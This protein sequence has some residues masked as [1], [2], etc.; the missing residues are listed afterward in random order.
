[1]DLLSIKTQRK[2]TY[3]GCLKKGCEFERD[4]SAIRVDQKNM[5]Y[6]RPHRNVGMDRHKHAAFRFEIFHMNS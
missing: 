6:Q 4:L 1:M 5:L 3:E 2:D